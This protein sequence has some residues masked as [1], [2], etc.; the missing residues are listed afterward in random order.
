MAYYVGRDVD[1]FW[2]TEHESHGIKENSTNFELEVEALGGTTHSA[3]T[4]VGCIADIG[5]AFTKLT[6]VTGVDLSIGSQ[7]EDITYMGLRNVGKIEIKKDT[8]ITVT[9]KKKDRKFLQLYQ[10]N[11]KSTSAEDGIGGHTARWG[12]TELTSGTDD[13]IQGGDIDPKSCVDFDNNTATTYG[14]RVIIEF[15]GDTDGQDGDGAA[16]CIPNCTISEVT[17]TTSNEAADEESL[18]FTSQ[19]KPFI[20][21]ARMNAETVSGSTVPFHISLTTQTPLTEV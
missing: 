4:I 3:D 13:K 8:S 11:V 6:D 5:E 19:V 20:S 18:T 15:K 17:H 1:V 14:Y 7:D 21:N 10:G 9:M 12:M 2:S 16:I